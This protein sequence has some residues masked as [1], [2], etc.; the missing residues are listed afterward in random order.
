LSVHWNGTF[1][2]CHIKIGIHKHKNNNYWIQVFVA[3]WSTPIGMNGK[4]VPKNQ[5]FVKKQ[6][7]THYP[8]NTKFEWV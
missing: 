1:Q 8:E 4:F 5:L 2:F 6:Q 7:Q 3:M